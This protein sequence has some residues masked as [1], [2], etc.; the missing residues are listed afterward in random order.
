[1]KE[2]LSEAQL[3]EV[4]ARVLE[5]IGTFREGLCNSSVFDVKGYW[6]F[7]MEG[8]RPMSDACEYVYNTKEKLLGWI[9]KEMEMATREGEEEL[10]Y[11]QRRAAKDKVITQMMQILE[12][13]LRGRQ[14]HY[15]Y[16]ERAVNIAEFAL[17]QGEQLNQFSTKG[18]H[19]A[20]IKP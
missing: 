19:L 4:N 20:K 10:Y 2:K 15:I 13:A 6:R 9:D 8:N 3:Q 12:P 5:I 16:T 14:E 17:R 1:M 18:K 11:K 7:G